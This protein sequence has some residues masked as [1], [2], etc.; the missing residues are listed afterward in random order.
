MAYYHNQCDS[1]F[2]ESHEDQEK[3]F[4]DG[5]RERE[6]RQ[7]WETQLAIAE[8]LSQLTSCEYRDDVLQHMETMEVKRLEARY[9]I[10]L[11]LTLMFRAKRCQ[12]LPQ[13]ISRQRSNGSCVHTSLTS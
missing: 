1:Y 11:M 9:L 6:R 12:T 7:K 8:D 10:T 4:R 3:G 2:V 5:L 13:S